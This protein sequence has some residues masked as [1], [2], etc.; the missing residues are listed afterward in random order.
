MK[1]EHYPEITY[2]MRLAREAGTI[3]KQSFCLGMER[4]TKD[5]DT[6]LT[7][8]DTAINQ[9]VV[10]SIRKDYPHIRV[11]GEE[12]NYEV[13]GAE[14]TVLCDP[15]DGT[16]PFCRGTPISAFTI[17]VIREHQPI[18]AVIY[19]PFMDRLWHAVHR[20]GAFL[21]SPTGVNQLKVSTHSE[22]RRS[23]ICMVWWKGSSFNLHEHL[24]LKFS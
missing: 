7:A 13:E 6:P 5:D 16:I 12:G 3:I 10:D 8:A 14:Y 1:N 4:I 21:V 20:R 19:D 23:N 9:L 2:L 11:I 15:I 17:S 18:A 24:S 22:I